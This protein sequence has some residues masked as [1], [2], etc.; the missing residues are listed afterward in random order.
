[1]GIGFVV[2]VL[3]GVGIAVQVAVLGRT[4]GSVSPLAVSLA[5]QVSGVAVAAVWATSRGAW[6]EVAV[7]GRNWWWIPLG[8]GGWAVVAALGFAS[9][10][11][12]VAATLSLSVAAQLVAGLVIDSTAGSSNLEATTIL[13]AVLILSGATLIVATA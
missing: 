10:R 3:V 6:S 9:N 12:G 4:S 8:A 2:A 5:L 11:V 13:G 1:M 7:V